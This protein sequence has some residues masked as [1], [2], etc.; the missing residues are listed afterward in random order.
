LQS[1]QVRACLGRYPQPG[2]TPATP[3]VGE[4]LVLSD[5]HLLDESLQPGSAEEAMRSQTFGIFI[6]EH[7]SADPL[8]DAAHRHRER[9][10]EN[11]LPV[12]N[13]AHGRIVR[14][15]ST[16]SASVHTRALLLEGALRS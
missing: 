14:Q 7:L 4:L 13:P 1:R 15:R 16:H 6:P 12:A 3:A 9:L 5:T 10:I 11:R 2:P 8:F